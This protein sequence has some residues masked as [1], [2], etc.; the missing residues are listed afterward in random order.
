M[1]TL[2]YTKINKK[3]LHDWQVLWEKSPYANYVN[4]P[5][6]FASTL[7]S[8]DYKDYI[9]IGIYEDT[10]LVAVAYFFKEKKYGFTFYTVP[11]EDYVCGTPFLTDVQNKKIMQILGEKLQELG[12]VFLDNI[13]ADVIMGL[14]ESI[15]DMV[16]V[17]F[18]VNYY[19]DFTPDS[20]GELIIAKKGKYMKKIKD[21]DDK[22]ELKSFDGTMPEALEIVFSLDTQSRKQ[23][24][25]YNIFGNI[26]IK[27]FYKSL[28]VN[29]KKNLAINILYLENKP[30]AYEMGF[31][32]GTIYFGSQIAFLGEYSYF[33]PGKIL[34]IKLFEKLFKENMK[35][36]DFGSGDNQVKKSFSSGEKPLYKVIISKNSLKRKYL[37]SMFFSK[38]RLFNQIKKHTRT[39]TMYRTIKK[40]LEK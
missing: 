5:Y 17:P 12:N 15:P 28:A 36:A 37:E 2:T 34:L 35:R 26:R 21:F 9:I 22:L 29:F 39:Y 6:W 18:S 14:K 20:R 24:R 31:P 27:N 33:A 4:S 40:S 19:L 13:H 7:A 1:K 38:D 3:L 32:I 8:F 30:I 16:S 10:T 11:P 23:K 25:G